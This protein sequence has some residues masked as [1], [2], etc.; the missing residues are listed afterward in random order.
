M[1]Y[2]VKCFTAFVFI[3][4]ISRIVSGTSSSRETIIQ[5]LKS[6]SPTGY[7]IVNT[8]ETI[9]VDFELKVMKWKTKKDNFMEFVKSDKIEDLLAAI[10]IVVHETCHSYTALAAFKETEEQFGKATGGYHSYYIGDNTSMLVKRTETFESAKIA[11]SIPERLR[12]FRFKTYIAGSKYNSTQSYGIY[13]LLNEFNAY[14]HGNR[15]AYDM[16]PYYRDKISGGPGKWHGYFSGVNRSLSAYMEFKY[17]ILKY[18]QYAKINYPAVYKGIIENR[19]FSSA[20]IATDEKHAELVTDYFI[21]KESIY[22]DI[23]KTGITVYEDGTM[24][25]FGRKPHFSGTSHNL[26]SFHLLKKELS[27]KEYQVQYDLLKSI[28]DRN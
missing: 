4:L 7:Y 5:L 10:N 15:A 9:P 2:P 12:T 14:Y 1:R 6:Y 13:G 26:E 22:D 18:L 21:R 20:F 25:Y 11:D 17:Y 8:Y 23:R 24:Y 3:I 27:G 16:Y 19:E 28:A